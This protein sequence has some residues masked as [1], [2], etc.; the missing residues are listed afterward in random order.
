MSVEGCDSISFER[1]LARFVGEPIGETEGLPRRER[2]W[3]R[4]WAGIRQLPPSRRAHEGGGVISYR[5]SRQS[6]GDASNAHADVERER[7]CEAASSTAT[8]AL[9]DGPHGQVKQVSRDIRQRAQ[10]SPLRACTPQVAEPHRCQRNK[11]SVNGLSSPLRPRALCCV[12][13]CVN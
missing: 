5:R 2:T 13:L 11:P 6:R 10:R 4:V 3:S 9:H 12:F 8:G 7:V 1:S